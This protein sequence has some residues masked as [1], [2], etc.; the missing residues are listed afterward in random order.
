MVSMPHKNFSVIV[1]DKR[2]TPYIRK[3]KFEAKLSWAKNDYSI[4][5]VNTKRKKNELILYNRFYGMITHTNKWGSEAI[6]KTLNKTLVNDTLFCVVEQIQ[7]LKGNAKIPENKIVISGHDRAAVFID[8]A[9]NVGDTVKIYIGFEGF[10]GKIEDLVGG[11]TQL[12]TDGRNS[13]IESF[14]K[15]GTAQNRERFALFRHPR[16]AIGFNKDKSKL[17]MV[18]VDG[19]QQSSAGMTLPELAD[20][21]VSLGAYQALNFDGG[22]STTMVVEGKVVNSP[23]DPMGERAVS[24]A[25]MIIKK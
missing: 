24:N 15:V 18:T 20:Y 13:A 12:V 10:P 5:G 6:L 7:R 19:R 14:D 22:G 1:F 3:I 8:T 17:F 25:L 23:S 21:M 4:N 16:T 9:L 11:F 2:N